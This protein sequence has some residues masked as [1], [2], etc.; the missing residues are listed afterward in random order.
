[1]NYNPFCRTALA[2]QG[3]LGTALVSN[4]SVSKYAVVKFLNYWINMMLISRSL[5]KKFKYNQQCSAHPHIIANYVCYGLNIFCSIE[6]ILSYL[7]YIE[8]EA[9]GFLWATLLYLI[10]LDRDNSGNWSTDIW[11]LTIVSALY[12]WLYMWLYFNSYLGNSHNSD[13]IGH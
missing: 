8:G 7:V 1:M 3:W 4:S 11:S 13:F 9:T 2:T 10:T 12:M 5:D 6:Y